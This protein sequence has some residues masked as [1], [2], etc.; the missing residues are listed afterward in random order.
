MAEPIDLPFGMVNVVSLVQIIQFNRDGDVDLSQIT[1]G[2]LVAVVTT[3]TEVS[4]D[5][6]VHWCLKNSFELVELSSPAVDSDGSDEGLSLKSSLLC[7]TVASA[8]CLVSGA[9]IISH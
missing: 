3:V 4:R 5:T 2:T 1:Y 7:R 9:S 8:C 6:A